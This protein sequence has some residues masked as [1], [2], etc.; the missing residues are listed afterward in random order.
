MIT[1]KY[2]DHLKTV[3]FRELEN[4]TESCLTSEIS[5]WLDAGNMP[6][7]PDSITNIPTVISMA[8]ARLAL[9]SANLL[10]TVEQNIG[11]MSKAA[12]IDWQ[13]RQTVE[14]NSPL[15]NTFATTM[16]LDSETLDALFT[17]ASKL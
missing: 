4:G 16:N 11:N 2:A 12:Q 5:E 17:T 10:D 6:E 8:Q 1:W 9:L 14:R 15:V 7:E 3:V 13:F